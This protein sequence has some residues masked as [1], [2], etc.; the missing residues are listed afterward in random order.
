MNRE[1]GVGGFKAVL[2][3]ALFLA[4]VF[5]GIK[6]VPPYINNFEFQSDLDSI[7]RLSTYAQQKTEEDVRTDVMGKAKELS[8]P[9]KPEQI[10]VTKS[11]YGVNINVKYTVVVEVP[12]YS[13]HL[14]FNPV[15]GNKMITAPKD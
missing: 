10:A 3:V 6:L 7:A 2:A 14:K 1:S 8:L 9:I 11:T 13:F 4:V 15:A 12:G 5:L